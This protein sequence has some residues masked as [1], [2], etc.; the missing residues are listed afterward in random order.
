MNPPPAIV[1]ALT[2]A[3]V[4]AV[5]YAVSI[6]AYLQGFEHGQLHPACQED[7]VLAVQQDTNPAHGLTW[8]CEGLDI[9]SGRTN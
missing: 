7:E 6:F 2:V 1:N 5:I 9:V 8:A 3:A 4:L